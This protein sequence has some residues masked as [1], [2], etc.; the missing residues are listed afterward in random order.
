MAD[1]NE[2]QLFPGKQCL[3]YFHPAQPG[4][5]PI[6]FKPTQDCSNKY[7]E[8]KQCW[9]THPYNRKDQHDQCDLWTEPHHQMKKC[10]EIVEICDDI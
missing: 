3:P 4:Q 1:Y 9:T 7:H 6:I 5:C 8:L 10:N 2:Y